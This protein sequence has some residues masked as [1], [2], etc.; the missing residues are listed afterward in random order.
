MKEMVGAET[1]TDWILHNSVQE[2]TMVLRLKW[3]HWG[4][5][6]A[7]TR[8]GCWMSRK[9]VQAGFPGPGK[10]TEHQFVNKNLE[11]WNLLQKMLS[12]SY[13]SVSFISRYTCSVVVWSL[14]NSKDI[15]SWLEFWWQP[16]WIRPAYT[17]WQGP[18]VLLNSLQCTR[19]SC[20]Q[21]RTILSEMSAIVRRKLAGVTG[22]AWPW[23]IPEA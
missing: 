22:V 19:D 8:A 1:N 4:K 15:W 9:K 18:A 23:E 21:Q 16:R 6:R 11:W 14:P 2:N 7:G 3:K 20:Q 10:I 13:T 17:V 5:I 12:L